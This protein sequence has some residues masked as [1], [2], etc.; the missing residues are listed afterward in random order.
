MLNTYRVNKKGISSGAVVLIVILTAVI[1]GAA[2]FFWQTYK[3]GDA[4]SINKELTEEFNKA[5]AENEELKAKVASL[6][7]ELEKLKNSAI[8]VSDMNERQLI[9]SKADNVLLAL[10]SNNM[11]RLSE[12][13]HPDK[14]VRFTP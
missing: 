6:E 11:E 7:S 8:P 2:V 12:L 10:K 3:Y 14:G 9:L 4:A 5:K 1:V 13:V